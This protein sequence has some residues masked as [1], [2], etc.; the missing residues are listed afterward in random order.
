MRLGKV[1][2]N[3]ISKMADGWELGKDQGLHG[4]W[5]IQEGGLGRGGNAIQGLPPLSLHSLWKNKVIIETK[6]GFPTEH[7]GLTPYGYLLAARIKGEE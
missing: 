4:H 2:K 1:Q 6:E 5:W 7:F 3:I